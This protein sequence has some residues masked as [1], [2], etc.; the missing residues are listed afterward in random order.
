MY[1]SGATLPENDSGD[2]PKYIKLYIWVM[3]CKESVS[4]CMLPETKH[5]LM[6]QSGIFFINLACFGGI[7]DSCDPAMSIL[8][9]PNLAKMVFYFWLICN[10]SVPLR[11]D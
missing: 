3:G 10:Q 7:R 11:H 4:S 6:H 5:E 1:Q 2:I 9:P 8:A